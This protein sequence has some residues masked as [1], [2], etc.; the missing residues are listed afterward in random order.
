VTC[1]HCGGH[2]VACV[3]GAGGCYWKGWVHKAT[4]LHA[5]VGGTLSLL[6]PSAEPAGPPTPASEP[7]GEVA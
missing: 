4:A 6:S 2:I 3:M 7:Q 1:K 5:C